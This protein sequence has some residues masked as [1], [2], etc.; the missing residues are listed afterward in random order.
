MSGTKVW[1]AHNIEKYRRKTGHLTLMEHGAYRLLMD[2]Y[3]ERRAP[4]PKDETRLRKIIG[5]DQDEWEAVREAVLAFFVLTE[6]GWRHEKIDENIA[7][8]ERLHTEK[9]ERLAMAREAKRL[10]SSLSTEQCTDQASGLTAGTPSPSPSPSHIL[11]DTEE[12]DLGADE[13]KA[14]FEEFWNLYPRRLQDSGGLTRGAKAKAKRQWDRLKPDERQAALNGLQGYQR[15]NPDKSRGVVDAE[16]YL[17]DA[18]WN[19]AADAERAGR[20]PEAQAKAPL[21]VP[22]EP[23]IAEIWRRLLHAVGER[24]ARSYLVT[25]GR[26]ALEQNC[27]GYVLRVG[28]HIQREKLENEMRGQLDGVLGKGQWR[29][30]AA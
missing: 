14:D 19:D 11:T 26:P 1:Y 16:R 28:S 9:A 10:R 21:P 15:I 24:R 29:T 23:A 4:L 13:P 22:D 3:W 30:E 17:R 2:A 6:D 18:R 5:A 8:A 27:T 25:A 20:E 7:E 12:P